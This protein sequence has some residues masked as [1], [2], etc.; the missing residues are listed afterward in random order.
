MKYIQT[1]AILL[2]Q[3]QGPVTFVYMDRVTQADPIREL[4]M[5]LML[6]VVLMLNSVNQGIW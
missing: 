6:F 3:G 1:T 4:M 2:L 5:S